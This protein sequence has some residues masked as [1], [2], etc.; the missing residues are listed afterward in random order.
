M[1]QPL[2]ALIAA[3]PLPPVA[4]DKH[5]RGDA[6]VV[7][8]SDRCPGAATLAATAALR[9]GVGRVQIITSS[10]I[11]TAVGIA[12]PEAYVIGW[13][14][15]DSLPAEGR[16]YLRAA[17]AVLVGP[18]LDYEAD[19]IACAIA[20]PVQATTPLLMDARS[21]HAVPDLLDRKLRVLCMPN[22]DEANDLVARL[23]ITTTDRPENLA[24]AIAQRTGAPAA[25][26]GDI[27]FLADG[28]N[29]Y[30]HE[31]PP[32]LGTAGSGDVFAGIAVGLTARGIDPMVALAWTIASHAAAGERLAA[33]RPNPGYLAREIGDALP[34]ALDAL[35]D[36]HGAQSPD[37]ARCKMA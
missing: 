8:G 33:G 21:L 2:A 13:T 10:H 20:S 11:A 30:F 6:V 32:S 3:S 4:G 37:A 35:R 25:V 29:T 26:R 22:E 17:D 15:G 34:G 28:S 18:G 19:S 23:A 27:T 16:D 36:V 1:T 7:A 24:R 12:V 5:R 14:V 31:G 9:A